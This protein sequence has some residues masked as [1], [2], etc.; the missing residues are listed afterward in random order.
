MT[1]RRVF[2][3]GINCPAETW[4]AIRARAKARGMNVSRFL[5]S[6][7]LHD[8]ALDGHPLVLSEEQQRALMKSTDLVN[9]G[10]RLLLE[11]LP[12]VGVTLREAV[13]ILYLVQVVTERGGWD[14]AD[15]YSHPVPDPDAVDDDLF[16][17]PYGEPG[18]G[19][20]G[21]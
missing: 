11:P 2:P 9:E 17:A 7:A 16:D 13:A 5:V 10:I 6:C 12:H 4:D 20:G 19:V 15:F 8:D 1:R 21:R 18:G 14:P 3:H